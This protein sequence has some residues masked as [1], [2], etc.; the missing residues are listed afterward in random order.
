MHTCLLTC[1]HAFPPSLSQEVPC[2]VAYWSILANDE[3][4]YTLNEELAASSFHC[5]QLLLADF[6]EALVYQTRSRLSSLLPGKSTMFY[7]L[8]RDFAACRSSKPLV[9][10]ALGGGHHA[11]RQPHALCVGIRR[12]LVE[13]SNVLTFRINC[14]N[15]PH[16][17]VSVGA[18]GCMPA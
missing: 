4:S 9:R 3:I 1:L 16:C 13:S 14:L 7:E 8:M 6:S 17:C 12:R 5:V 11:L 10:R 18:C 2:T 15:V